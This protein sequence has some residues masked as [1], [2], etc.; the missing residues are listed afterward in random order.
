MTSSCGIHGRAKDRIERPSRVPT[1]AGAPSGT[2]GR[3]VLEKYSVALVDRYA[4]MSAT[5]ALLW[6]TRLGAAAHGFPIT[7]E[8]N[9]R[10][11]IAVTTGMGVFKLLTA[12]L[13]QDIYQPNGGNAIY[14]FALPERASR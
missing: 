6:Q 7:Y 11:Y 13:S 2:E 5:G 8:V 9:G 4:E 3:K 1:V 14:V 12:K 10:Q